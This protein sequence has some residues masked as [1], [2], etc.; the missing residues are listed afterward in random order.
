[1]DYWRE[2]LES[3]GLIHTVFEEQTNFRTWI[4]GLRGRVWL[5]VWLSFGWRL[6]SLSGECQCWV[7]VGGR[8]N[9]TLLRCA[10]KG[11]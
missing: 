11:D 1:M 10:A 9:V 7:E 3:W 2:V 4:G 5:R 6:W 8:G